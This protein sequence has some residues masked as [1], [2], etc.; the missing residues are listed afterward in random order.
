[1]N[2]S[3]IL[4][5]KVKSQEIS[6]SPPD[7]VIDVDYPL[8][9]T[10][11]AST[12]M[13]IEMKSAL[14][15]CMSMLKSYLFRI[16]IIII[17]LIAVLYFQGLLMLMSDTYYMKTN[18]I[19]L[20]DRVHELLEGVNHPFSPA[21]CNTLM[22]IIV[23]VGILRIVFF[24]PLFYLFQM[25]L[26]YIFLFGSAYFIRG[27]YI[28]ATTVPS[29]Y[30]NCNP[31]LKKRSFFPLLIRIIAGYMG[32]VTNCTDLI[33]SG[34]TVFTVITAILFVENSK[35]L[36]TKIIITLYTGFVLFLI[37]ACKYHYT[38]DVLLGLT[39]SVLLHYF[40]YTRVDDFGTYI[41]NKIFNSGS[42]IFLGARKTKLHYSLITKFIVK[43]ELLEE[44]LILGQKLRTLYLRVNDQKNLIDKN[45]LKKFNHMVR[46]FGADESDDLLTLFRGTR[47]MNFYYWKYLYRKMFKK[48]KIV[49]VI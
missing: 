12:S 6:D 42:E 28:F 11:D 48:K 5:P 47:R 13:E 44:R 46:L 43:M 26:R 10:I 38:V 27:F 30:L 20:L 35:Y 41:H 22:F 33:V 40:Y 8:P 37:V 31:D 36:V 1:M 17:A 32:L 7:L 29:C 15:Q 25:A 21:L 3:L 45:L 18:R 19:P 16:F 9:F 39:I 49:E 24:T 23:W 14:K 34:H 2:S 4:D